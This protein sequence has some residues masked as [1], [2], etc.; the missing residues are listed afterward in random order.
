MKR[1]RAYHSAVA[2]N[3]IIYVFGGTEEDTVEVF[4]NE[5]WAL[6]PFQMPTRLARVGLVWTTG[7]I[8]LIAGGAEGKAEDG[9]WLY[10]VSTT[11]FRTIAPLP[12]PDIFNSA[13]IYS[14]GNAYLIGSASIYEYNTSQRSWKII[15][16]EEENNRC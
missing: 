14:D 8:V 2:V 6:I 3:R 11:D 4:V 16:L 9:A 5:S 10:D 15:P 13:G 1:H 7:N 12:K